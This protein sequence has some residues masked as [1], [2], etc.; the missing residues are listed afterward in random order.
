MRI[1]APATVT[2]EQRLY[3]VAEPRAGLDP[4][5]TSRGTMCRGRNRLPTPHAFAGHLGELVALG[6]AFRPGLHLR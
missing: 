3:R 6:R 1:V 4:V 5:A 2:V